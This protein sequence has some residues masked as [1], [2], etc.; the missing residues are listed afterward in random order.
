VEGD[1][2]M[3]RSL[4]VGAVQ[5]LCLPFRGFSRSGAT[6]STGLLL[7]VQRRLIEEFSFA[8]AVVLTPFADGYELYRLLKTS[9]ASGTKLDVVHLLT[10]GLVGMV[11][12]FI[13]GY[14]ALKL[15]SSLLEAGKWKFFGIYC[16]VAALA[17][18]GLAFAGW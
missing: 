9:K 4:I 12:A 2:D 17:V 6:I 18:F 1:I 13:A 8:L 10:P 7:G 16:F 14:L 5:G 15:L 11:F 3:S